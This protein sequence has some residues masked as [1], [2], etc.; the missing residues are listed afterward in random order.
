MSGARCPLLALPTGAGK[1]VVVAKLIADHGRDRVL[2]LVPWRELAFQAC[3][4]LLDR[5]LDAGVLMGSRSPH[6]ERITVATVQTAARRTLADYSLIVID[7]AHRAIARQCLALLDH[8][9]K[10]RMVGITA[11]PRRHDGR[12]LSRAF[13]RLILGASTREL[14]DAGVL[15]P[16]IVYGPQVP[17]DLAEVRIDPKA[18]DYHAGDLG[19]ATARPKLYADALREWGKHARGRPCAVYCVNLAH[20]GAIADTYRAAGVR[21]AVIDAGTPDRERHQAFTDLRDR[22][23]DALVN[24]AV[25]TEGI[26]LPELEVLQVLR[27]T[28]SQTL[29]R[30]ILGRGARRAPGKVACVV[31]DHADNTRRHGWP[32]KEP[33]WSLDGRQNWNLEAAKKPHPEIRQC[34][35]CGRL[36]DAS[37]S[38]C[39]ECGTRT[40]IQTAEG[41]LVELSQTTITVFA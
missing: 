5:G 23:L 1:T 6:G 39:P 22:R 30:Q 2:F 36:L 26:D 24:V 28:L 13:D 7:E 17:I 31:L 33:D 25:L 12:A 14:I 27:P 16:W 41:R 37:I 4:R 10:A 20:A 21:L 3:A 38:S 34:P 8:Y 18:R 9:P 29:W 35:R 19:R 11:T 32:D 15:S 40:P